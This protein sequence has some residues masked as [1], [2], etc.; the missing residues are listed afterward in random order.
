MFADYRKFYQNVYPETARCQARSILPMTSFNRAAYNHKTNRDNIFNQT[1]F[2]YKTFTGP[3]FHTI[4]FGTEFGRQTGIS[5]ATP[6]S[7][8]TAPTQSSPTRLRRR[9]SGLSTSSI[10][11][12]RPFARRFR[13]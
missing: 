1:D 7:F 8:R 12:R 3:V 9:I 6:E 13:A 2:V 5:C 10:N 4:A 11:S